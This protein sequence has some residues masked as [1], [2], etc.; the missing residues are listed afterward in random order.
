MKKLS[1]LVDLDDP[2]WPLLQEDLRLATNTVECLAAS[3]PQRAEALV[4]LQVT[5]RSP[6]GA[7]VYET[8]GL[9]VDHG[10]LRILGSGHER[11]PRSLPA[12]NLG[13]TWEDPTVQP[14]LL[15]VADDV[16]GGLFALNGGAFPGKPGNSLYFDPASLGW[17]DLDVGYSEFLA[18]AFNGE[19]ESFY[20][21]HRWPGW[22]SE[23][24]AV[25]G[26]QAL[27]VYPFLVA[28]G[29][30]IAERARSTVPIGELYD[31]HMEMARQL[32]D[33]R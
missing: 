28:D 25:S 7:L 1:Q 26:G 9:L 13:R 22:E 4:Q 14:P 32:G 33:G 19:L 16:L 6:M 3:D 27:S 23:V 29:P 10:W 24:E 8:G 20:G 12:W 5:T 15:L 11:L 30:P 17:R 18:W 21:D 2:C 31:L